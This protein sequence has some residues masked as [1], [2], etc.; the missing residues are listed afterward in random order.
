[1]NILITRH[2]KIGDF[3]LTLPLC[4]AIKEQYPNTKLTLLVSKV[5]FEFAMNLEFIDDVFLFD[6]ENLDQTL[7]KIKSKKFDASI[8]AYID[9]TL[10]KIL[11]K[12]G[13]KK[14]VAPSTK[15][16][17][18]FFNKRVTQ[19]RSQALKTEWKYNLDL[20]LKIFPDLKLDFAKPLLNFDIKK[21]KRVVFHPGFGGSSDGNLSLDDYISLGRSILNTEYEVVFTF[22][23]DD[24]NSKEYISSKLDS[25]IDEKEDKRI[26]LLDSKMSLYEFSKYIASSYLFVSTSTGPMHLA[27]AVNTK[28]ISFF[29]STT[30]AS[31]K[32]WATIS[33]IENQN[34]FMLSE[35]YSKIDYK[36][37]EK[38]LK[39]LLL[40]E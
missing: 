37:I 30:F 6:K 25:L 32:R 28:S 36:E 23:P 31:S 17:Q 33:D 9:I 26:I 40:N 8:S 1:M 12:S 19:R 39:E 11:F 34:N 2:D 27:G 22:G 5:N 20:A 29:G 16:A 18:I 38:R 15:L 3:I 13:I 24:I 35:N 4:K 10:G 7:K 21:N 14:R